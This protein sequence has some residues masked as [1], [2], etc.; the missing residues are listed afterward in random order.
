MFFWNKNEFPNDRNNSLVIKTSEKV[1]T[2]YIEGMSDLNC[3]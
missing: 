2:K 1:K 3:H